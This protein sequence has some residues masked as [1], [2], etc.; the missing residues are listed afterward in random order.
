MSKRICISAVFVMMLLSGAALAQSSDLR[1]PNAA[2]QDQSPSLPANGNS[3]IAVANE[4]DLLRKSVQTLN[5]RLRDITDK[6]FAPETKEIDNSNDRVKR[7]S[8]NLELLGRAEE[9][10]E[11]LRKQL[12]DLI[13]KET[14]Y[15]SRMTQMDED[16]R[17]E[18]IERSLSGIGTTR[19]ME[20]RDTRRRTLENERKGLD[21][22]INQTSSSRMR[23]EEDVRQAD[24]LV[25]KLRLRLMPL[26]E[27][28]IDKINP[29]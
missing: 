6:L 24:L 13:E 18:N 20:L 3:M 29:N 25:T 26:I 17:P 23:L 1:Q 11:I 28:E 7:I 9:R 14:A 21:I 12:L 22:L 4:I 16:M 15:K 27:K 2:L 19:T 8:A 10:A 5:T